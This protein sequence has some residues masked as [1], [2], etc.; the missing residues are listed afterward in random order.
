MGLFRADRNIARMNKSALRMVMPEMDPDLFMRGMKELVLL[1]RNWIPDLTGRLALYTADDDRHRTRHVG[2]KMFEQ[3][4]VLYN[5]RPG[6]PLLS[7]RVQPHQDL[8]F[9]KN[10]CARPKAAWA[11]PRHRQL[12]VESVRFEPGGQGRVQPGPVAGRQGTPMGR[13][14]GHQQYFLPRGR[15]TCPRRRWEAPSFRA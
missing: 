8:R 12:R 7:R 10:S 13:G 11:K 6:G 15:R 4:P 2:V 9:G 5:C 14:S 3:V 1:D